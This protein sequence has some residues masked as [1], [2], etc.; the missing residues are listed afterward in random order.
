VRF[1]CVLLFFVSAICGVEAQDIINESIRMDYRPIP[2]EVEPGVSIAAQAQIGLNIVHNDFIDALLKSPDLRVKAFYA[3]AILRVECQRIVDE[4]ARPEGLSADVRV[5]MEG[6][7]V[8]YSAWIE[9]IRQSLR[10]SDQ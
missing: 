3:I 9:I 4:L 1:C 2:I 7:K 5:F 10:D 6:Q 8:K